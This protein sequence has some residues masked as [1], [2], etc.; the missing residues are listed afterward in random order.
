MFQNIEAKILPK[1][2]N[3]YHLNISLKEGRQIAINTEYLALASRKSGEICLTNF[4]DPGIKYKSIQKNKNNIIDLEFSPFDNKLLAISYDNREF[5]SILEFD[6][7]KQIFNINDLYHND[8]VYIKNFNSNKSKLNLMSSCTVNG[9]GYIWDINKLEYIK[10]FKTEKDP[11]GISWSPNGECF[12]ICFKNKNLKIYDKNELIA[13]Q[14]VSDR[15]ILLNNFDWIDDNSLVTIGW[16]KNE[17]KMKL[18]DIRNFKNN[19]EEI[20]LTNQNDK[21]DIL[22]FVN[23]EKRLIYTVRKE[24]SIISKPSIVLYY[25]NDEKKI[26]KKYEYSSPYP[27][28]C[29]V[30]LKEKTNQKNEI[31][32]FA[33]YSLRDKKVYFISFSV[34]NNESTILPIIHD[35]DKSETEKNKNGNNNIGKEKVL[36]ENKFKNLIKINN[37]NFSIVEKSKKDELKILKSELEEKINIIKDFNEKNSLLLKDNEKLINENKNK[38]EIIE[39]QTIKYQ[40]EQK[41]KEKLNKIIEE[42]EEKIRKLSKICEEKTSNLESL[43]KENDKLKEDLDK[44]IYKKDLFIS[45]RLEE[46]QEL[47]N[48]FINNKISY[49]KILKERNILEE[50]YNDV[51][52]KKLQLESELKKYESIIKENLSLIKNNKSLQNSKFVSNKEYFHDGQI[53]ISFKCCI[54]KS[55]LRGYVKYK[56]KNVSFNLILKNTGN[57]KWDKDTKLVNHVNSDFK[58]EDVILEPQDK[59]KEVTYKIHINDAETYPPSEYKAILSFSSNG[60]IIGEPLIYELVIYNANIIED[61]R[62][63]YQSKLVHRNITDDEIYDELKKNKSDF[64]ETFKVLLSKYHS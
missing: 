33:Q 3:Y 43:F 34:K 18:W 46:F 44:Q 17:Q 45:N 32:R 60:N 23:K 11:K 51:Y 47:N 55:Y 21:N 9:T 20:I 48:N 50:K 49:E 2:A 6:F 53:V 58:I 31:N 30:L 39:Q 5:I 24:E 37:E 19:F 27:S 15:D 59:G 4:Y 16:E 36:I 7:S 41:E 14:L 56:Q 64:N 54:P 10:E 38:Q 63:K 1:T 61:F 26:E 28:F 29:T 35:E 57:Y 8:K 42:N 22:P 25:L 13:E 40:S 62:K 12:G 52:Q